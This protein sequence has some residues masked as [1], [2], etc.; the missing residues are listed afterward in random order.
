[1]YRALTGALERWHTDGTLRGDSLLLVEHLAVELAGYRYQQLGGGGRAEVERWLDAFGD[2]VARAQQ[3]VHPAGPTAVEILSTV[4]G[5]GFPGQGEGLAVQGADRLRL[6]RIGAPYLLYLRDGH[7][8]ED[9][10][11][12]ALTPGLWAA[13]ALTQL[14]HD[15]RTRITAYIRPAVLP[16]CRRAGCPS[17]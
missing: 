1:M 8:V 10:G 13:A 4:V 3:H 6:A 17:W 16:S 14:L 12:M 11:E 2:E 15:D 5:E 9:A 7:Q